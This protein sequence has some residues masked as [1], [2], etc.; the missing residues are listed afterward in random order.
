MSKP[1]VIEKTIRV[2]AGH[3]KLG[4]KNRPMQCPIARAVR[5]AGFVEP[6]VCLGEICARRGALTRYRAILPASA[7]QFIDDFDNGKPVEPFEFAVKFERS[8]F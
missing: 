1:D 6:I 3:I 7:M 4:L 5:G 8:W 2:Q